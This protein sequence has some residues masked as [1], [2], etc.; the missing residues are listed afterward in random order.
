VRACLAR[1]GLE[2]EV[3][4]RPVGVPADVD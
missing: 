1:T 4:Q 3:D 2:F